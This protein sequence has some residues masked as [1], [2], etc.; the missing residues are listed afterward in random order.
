M[1]EQATE[2]RPAAPDPAAV[3]DAVT[4][5]AVLG[6]LLD[7]VKGAYQDARRDAHELL[8]Q[9]HKATGTTKVDA[10]LPDGTK[11]GSVSRQGGERAAQVVDED[12]FTAWVRDHYPSEHVVKVIPA[13]VEVSVQPAF[14]SKI[15]AEMTAA[16]VAQYADPNTGELHTVPGVD[17]RPSRTAAHRITYGRGS[18]AQPLTGRE[19]VE[20][21]WREGTLAAHVLPALAPAAPAAEPKPSPPAEART[22]PRRRVGRRFTA[23][24]DGACAECHGD[25]YEGDE[26]AYVDDELCCEDCADAAA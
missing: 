20:R 2:Q 17:I 5:Q 15:L 6:A 1:T 24:F 19:L 25:F 4:R 23:A 3:R 7:K 11:V 10:L 26:V 18:K 16:G 8:E 12:A 13:R 22:A 9:Q 21:A 14:A